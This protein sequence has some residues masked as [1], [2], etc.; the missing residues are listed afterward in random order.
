[1]RKIRTKVL[2]P[3]DAD[4]AVLLSDHVVCL[5]KGLITGLRPYDPALDADCEDRRD[6]LALPGL[7]DIHV[8][9]SQYRIRGL[10]EPSLLAWLD[11]HVFPAEALSQ[12]PAYAR[13]ISEDFFHALFACGTTTSVIYTAPYHS[14]CEIAFETAQK[15]GARAFIGMT[16]MDMDS[17]PELLQTTDY[18]LESS[19]E[20]YHRF[21]QASPLLDYIFTPRFALS[22]S[23]ELLQKMASFAREH[24]AWIQTHL[25]ENRDEIK[26][27]NELFGS[28]SYTQLYESLGLLSP[29]T[30]L[31]HAIHLSDKEMD[32]LAENGCRVA[33][34]PDSN[35][36]LKSGE[37][38]YS[39]L[40]ARKIA[41]GLGSD[42][43]A[44]TTLSMLYHAKLANYRQSAYSLKP[45][46]I[47]YH[48]T[49][50]NAA[51]L[52]LEKRIG[53]LEPGK[54][55]DLCL[56]KLPRQPIPD[57]D[58]LSA[59]CFWGHEFPVA[60]TVIAGKTVFQA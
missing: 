29:K 50:G 38:N 35:F 24:Q 43:A 34:C 18:A 54:E 27:V 2:N 21:H 3:I 1:M 58:L 37:F 8:H 41:I 55:A 51:V 40:A 11:K 59:L 7:I 16:L 5:D 14:A 26:R 46:R 17:P 44:G 36:F 56:L 4:S 48:I 42:V 53:S 20:L 45:E 31:A 30:I 6:L 10:Y 39:E 15:L 47:F 23:R 9:L 22:C 19:I 32:T 60:E 25:S 57:P 52:N 33:H 28:E 12:D 49:L 13:S